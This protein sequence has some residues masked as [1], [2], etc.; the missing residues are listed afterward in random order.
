MIAAGIMMLIIVAAALWL[1][2][3]GVIAEREKAA[4]RELKDILDA[5]KT[6]RDVDR[7]PDAAMDER[8]HDKW[9]RP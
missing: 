2:K 4:A 3:S 9:K 7:L 5:K 8:L 6:A 1:K